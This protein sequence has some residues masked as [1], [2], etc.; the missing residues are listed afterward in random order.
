M[1]IKKPQEKKRKEAFNVLKYQKIPENHI[2]HRKMKQHSKYPEPKLNSKRFK[3]TDSIL[4][5]SLIEQNSK[6]K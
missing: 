6:G 1:I 5:Q 3:Q 2:T 4:Y